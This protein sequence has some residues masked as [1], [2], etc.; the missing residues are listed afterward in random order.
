MIYDT[1][2]F[3]TPQYN[4]EDM[5]IKIPVLE[6]MSGP[7]DGLEFPLIKTIAIV[8]RIKGEDISLP[9]DTQISRKH[10][11]I[12]LIENRIIIEDLNSTN[13]TFVYNQQISGKVE[14]PLNTIF[15]IGE[16]WIQIKM[17]PLNDYK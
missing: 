15:R 9:L 12:A 4:E 8:G 17:G 2:F 5:G 10:L 6:V 11:K 14:V 13:G 3:S 16:T 7:M 1:D